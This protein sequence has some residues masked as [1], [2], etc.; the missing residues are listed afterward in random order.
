MRSER[1]DSYWEFDIRLDG[2]GTSW[3]N[4]WRS[5]ECWS[6]I[7]YLPGTGFVLSIDGRFGP[8]RHVCIERVR[9]R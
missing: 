5:V 2:A 6:G 9:M 3:C 1:V 8:D 4:Y 7:E